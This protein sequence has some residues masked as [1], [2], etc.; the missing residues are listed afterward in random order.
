LL[1]GFKEQ[2][3]KGNLDSDEEKAT[4][5]LTTAGIQL[6]QVIFESNEVEIFINFGMINRRSYV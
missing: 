2:S 4:P 6:N 1:D 5:A 3:F